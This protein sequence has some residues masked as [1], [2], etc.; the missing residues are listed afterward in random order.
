[1][2]VYH[3][4]ELGPKSRISGIDIYGPH[5]CFLGNGQKHTS[6]DDSGGDIISAD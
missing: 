5:A 1:M 4:L 6:M 2:S 3:T